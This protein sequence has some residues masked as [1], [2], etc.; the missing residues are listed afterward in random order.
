MGL[1][2]FVGCCCQASATAAAASTYFRC[3]CCCVFRCS[4]QVNLIIK[5]KFNSFVDRLRL[6]LSALSA[7]CLECFFMQPP[8]SGRDTAS[9]SI[10]VHSAPQNSSGISLVCTP[11]HPTPLKKLAPQLQNL[12][13]NVAGPDSSS[14]FC[15]PSLLCSLELLL[16]RL[17]LVFNNIFQ[18][19]DLFLALAQNILIAPG[20]KQKLRKWLAR[21]CSEIPP[22]TL[23]P[24]DL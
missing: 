22:Q 1:K 16:Q 21:N 14:C 23:S 13:T 4:C 6:Q 17:L 2:Y 15:S 5:L 9:C 11:P 7:L 19:S 10:E 8:E 18:L 24:R 3:C 20:H 12:P